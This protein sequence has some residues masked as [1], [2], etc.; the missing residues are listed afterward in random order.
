MSVQLSIYYQNVRG[1]RTKLQD[2]YKNVLLCNYQVIIF[3]ETWLNDN[4]F[5]AE[6]LDDR[7]QIFRRD[8]QS[9]TFSKDKDGGGVLIAVLKSL[10]ACRNNNLE[11]FCE[12]LWI[13]IEYQN[14]KIH[15][16]AMCYLCVYAIYLPPPAKIECVSHFTTRLANHI[17]NMDNKY[18]VDWRF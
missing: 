15:L 5:T 6:I 9:N 1:I 2:V 7:Y 18:S 4:I 3:T 17:D 14:H 11:S 8:R 16:C 12:D 13:T 10:S